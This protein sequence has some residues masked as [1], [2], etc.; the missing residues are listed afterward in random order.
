MV[1]TER[2]W[3][4]PCLMAAAL[5]L[6]IAAPALAVDT[7]AGGPPGSATASD[8]G[9]LEEIVVTAQRKSENVLRVPVSIS[10]ATGDQLIA[11]GITQVSSLQFTV[12][13][14]YTD[15]GVG[16]TQ[17]YLRGIG[18]NIFVGADP[19]VLTNIDDV[20]RIYGSLVNNFVNVDRVEV[21]KGAQGGLY[22]RN[23]TGGVVNIITR[24]PSDTAEAD[25]RV[26]YGQKNTLQVA[27]YGNLPINDVL[28]W[29]VA[30]ER[31]SHDNYVKNLL[32]PN[33]LTAANFPDG[34]GFLLGLPPSQGGPPTTVATPAQTAAFFNSAINP[35][36]GYGNQ[37]FWAGDTK[38]R[39]QLAPNFKVTVDA[40]WSQKRDSE[41]DQWF[42][43]TPAYSQA[44]GTGVLGAFGIKIALPPGFYAP[45]T[46]PFTTYNSTP[47]AAYLTDYG[48]SIKPEWN[49]PGVDITNIAAYRQQQT[50]YGQNY[51]APITV[52]VP[53]VQNQKW[54]LY[55]ELR[56]ISTDSGP[57]HFLGG[58]TYLRDHTLGATT[59]QLFPPLCCIPALAGAGINT[60]VQSTDLVDNYSVY[61]QV[62]YDIT[63]KLNFTTSLRWIHET[64][65]ANFTNPVNST[66]SI[67]AKKYLPSATLSY[68]LD[69][70]GNVY[71][72]YAKGFKAGGVN[73]V[74]PPTLFPSDFGKVFGP[75][76]VNTYEAGFKDELFDHKVQV[77]SAVF[78]NDYNGL[79][80]TTA[81]NPQHPALIEAIIN[82]GTAETY[83]AEGSVA[84]RV[85]RPLTLSAN[86]A[87]LDA[88]YRTFS[89]SDGSVLATFNFDGRGMIN[90]P[91]WQFAFQ[92]MLDQPITGN[93]NLTGT[94]QTAYTSNVTTSYTVYPGI[95]DAI[96]PQYWLTNLRIGVKTPDDRYQFSIFANNVFDRAYYTFYSLSSLSGNAL[97][98]NPRIVGGEFQVKFR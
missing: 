31:D 42:N 18:N 6:M 91:K 39:L 67:E 75:E 51:A 84:W 2:L 92:G 72:R 80:Y 53:L 62:G 76:Q 3:W 47:A 71:V 46:H 32:Q 60:Y 36:S 59:N 49:L 70:G 44:Y 19:S 45:V 20:P 16:Y 96:I 22:G 79:Q 63:S 1:R 11:A 66:S 95:P 28:A 17:I 86:A 12:P 29:N 43:T 13:G 48:I 65:E 58:A 30:F 61:G 4:V 90:S 21:L 24:Q 14:F 40:D 15:N 73:P 37:D 33:P 9:G 26:S 7:A 78:Y 25:A 85:I 8:T 10:A 89:N 50:V 55:E 68:A 83:G 77:T 27:L 56:A 81:G 94:W 5:P 57:F 69:G 64:N 82:V 54:Y 93:L 35:Q 38:V 97:W 74:V 88:R 98:G 23:A 87:Y 52:D 34:G 41:G